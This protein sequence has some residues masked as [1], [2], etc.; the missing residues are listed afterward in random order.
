[1]TLGRPLW[2]LTLLVLLS[3]GRNTD[4]L[5]HIVPTP[6]PELLSKSYPVK[7]LV[8][9]SRVDILW[10]ID[11]S[12]SMYEDQMEVIRNTK[13]FMDEFTLKTVV[14]WK[15]GLISTD[16]NGRPYVG[17]P[18]T[19][20]LD[21]KSPDPVGVFQAA[22]GNLGTSGSAEEMLYTP[23]KKALTSHPDFLRDDA[24]LAIIH[25]SD[26][27]EQ[28]WDLTSQEFLDFLAIE[29]GDLVRV[30]G[31]GVLWPEEWCPQFSGDD[32]FTF[33]GSK[34]EELFSAIKGKTYPLCNMDFGRDLADLGKDIVKRI[35]SPRIPLTKRPKVSTIRVIYKDQDL[36]GGLKE[37]GGFWIYDFGLNAILF[38]DLDFA[39]G[40]KE[41]VKVEYREDDGTP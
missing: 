29:K 36:P 38:H 14:D 2:I 40:D 18:G 24:M 20:A 41:E 7:E 22:V 5:H 33:A 8:G 11:N 28:S 17:F 31:Y 6:P 13:V 15:M 34:Y 19:P 32:L 3:C 9:D 35:T 16:Q 30:L 25:I 12:G 4:F 37:E 39:P 27:P 1:M 26:A 23:V 21:K 10:V